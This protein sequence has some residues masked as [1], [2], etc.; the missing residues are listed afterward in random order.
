MR[1]LKLKAF[2]AG[3]GL[4]QE[5]MAA[6]LE[7]SRGR[8]AGIEAGARN[9]DQNFWLKFQKIFNLPDEKMWEIMTEKEGEKNA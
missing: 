7:C 5:Q 6:K 4:N 8:Y 2:R 1:R 9:G 3:L